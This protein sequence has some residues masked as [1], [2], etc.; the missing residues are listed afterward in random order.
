MST[1]RL[2]LVDDQHPICIELTKQ[3]HAHTKHQPDYTTVSQAER[4]YHSN[5]L[6]R[7]FL[8]TYMSTLVQTFKSISAATKP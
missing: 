8:L 1:C 4:S 5:A 2:I 6:N 3:K 7:L